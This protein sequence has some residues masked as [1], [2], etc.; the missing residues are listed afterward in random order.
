MNTGEIISTI[1]QFKDKSIL[2]I[3]DIMLDEYVW[4]EVKRISA[5]APVQI[6]NVNNES[7]VPGG[8]ANV[9]SNICALGAKAAIVGLIGEDETGKRLIDELKRRGINADGIITDPNRPTTTKTRVMAQNQQLIRVDHEK[10]HSPSEDQHKR[11]I[12][13]IKSTISSYDLVAVSDYSKGVITKDLMGKLKELCKENRKKI[14]VDPK[15]ENMALY[16]NVF[17]ITP[18]HIEASKFAGIKEENSHDSIKEIGTIIQKRLDTHLLITRGSKGMTL[19]E[20][21][22]DPITI[23]TQAKEIYDIT[24]AGDSAFAALAVAIASGSSLRTASVISNYAAGIVVGKMGTATASKKELISYFEERNDKVKGI[25]ELKQ[26]TDDLKKKGK[27]VVWTNGCFDILHSGHTKYLQDAKKLGDILILGL[28]TDA[29][30]KRLKGKDR[31]IMSENERAEILSALECID[32][33]TFFGE[34][35]P[36]NAIKAIVPHI[37]AKGGDYKVEDVVGK[38]IV[39]KEKGK[40]VIIPL[41]EGLST[42]NIINNILKSHS[43]NAR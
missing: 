31:P 15:P 3:G 37:I 7:F 41:K 28:N 8:A 42:S 12:Q 14:I 34:D 24:G 2:V 16:N 32:Y 9:A 20:K 26:I 22:K 10:K 18:N 25:E 17:M 4:G 5:E 43:S 6:V 40:V 39:E 11:I 21:G 1:N 19:F 23:L 35:T 38:D 33:I 30:V 29:S 13:F 27:K 36:F